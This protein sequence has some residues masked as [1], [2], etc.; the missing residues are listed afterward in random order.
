MKPGKGKAK[1]SAFERL[2]CKQL[3][4]WVSDGKREDLF[5]R[6]AMS[7]GRATQRFAKG[8]SVKTQ[9]GDISAVDPL[10]HQLTDRYYIECKAYNNLNLDRFILKGTGNLA[11]FWETTCKEATKYHRQPM[12]IARQ[13]QMPTFVMVRF[14]LGFP[15]PFMALVYVDNEGQRCGIL[16]LETMVGSGFKLPKVSST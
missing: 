4:I 15:A 14:T 10:G 9:M 12:L 13:N 7:G 2:V 16:L 3:S 5:W 11:N 1:G 6:S 8:Q